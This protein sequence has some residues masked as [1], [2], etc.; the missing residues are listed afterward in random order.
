ML[1]LSR[2]PLHD[3]LR[4]LFLLWSGLA[5]AAMGVGLP[6]CR[7]SE[8]PSGKGAK[9]P[10]LLYCAAG[11]KTPVTEIA[12]AYQ[13]EFGVPV[14]LQFGGSGTLLS[15][16]SIAA[17]GDLYLAG[18]ASYI[19]KARERGLVAESIPLATMRPVIAVAQGNPR[20]IRCVEDLLR[21][22][23]RVALAH[24]E[25]ASIGRTARELLTDSGHWSRLERHAKVFKPTVNDL[26]NDVRLGTADA[27]IIWDAIAHQYPAL[28]TVRIPELDAGVEQVTL[29][30]LT[31]TKKPSRALRFA[32]YV[33]SRDRGL[34]VFEKHGYNVVKGDVW[35]SEPKLTLYSGGVNR[36]AIEETL[37]QFE[38]REGVRIVSI[39]NGCG[40]L[41]AQMRAI[42]KGDMPEKMFPDAYFSCDTSFMDSVQDLFLDRTD[43]SRTDMVI[44]TK[45][46]NPAGIRTLHDLTREGLV[47]ALA[48]PLKSALGKLTRDML[49]DVGIYEEVHRNVKT[50]KPTADFLVADMRSGAIDAAIVYRANTTHAKGELE[51]VEIDHPRASAI[52]P[53]AVS[54]DSPHQRT[55]GRLLQAIRSAES[56]KRF[57]S[58]GFTIV[59]GDHQKER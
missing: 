2:V 11:M 49:E 54:R 9:E 26:A 14:R 41:T 7:S 18:D 28:D 10:I 46:G 36:V 37:K 50:E 21:D 20:K 27:A 38:K 15:N 34:P 52:Q 59:D 1:L 25:A 57:E 30:V 33:G 42:R 53:Y 29:G 58:A 4:P 56:Q 24:P 12:R 55:A 45:K 31:S 39:Y 35:E 22:D 40:I 47:L 19:H 16:L 32:R 51:I 48:H 43:M 8:S 5:A 44:I 3:R 6:G 13:S 23:V 17:S